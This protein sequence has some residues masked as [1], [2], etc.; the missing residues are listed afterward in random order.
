M[1][2]SGDQPQDEVARQF[3]FDL[4]A[5]GSGRGAGL[6]VGD[7]DAD[8]YFAQDQSWPRLAGVTGAEEGGEATRHPGDHEDPPC[9]K[10]DIHYPAA[11]GQGVRDRG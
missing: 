10:G 8:Q 11:S 4:A 9:L 5:G 3:G 2:G 7:P 1:S 6:G